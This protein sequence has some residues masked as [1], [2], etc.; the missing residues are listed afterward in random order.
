MKVHHI[1]ETW[2][3]G[4]AQRWTQKVAERQD[5][6]WNAPRTVVPH[7]SSPMSIHWSQFRLFPVKATGGPRKAHLF[8]CVHEW[9]PFLL[10]TAEAAWFLQ[11]WFRRHWSLFNPSPPI[12]VSSWIER[13]YFGCVSVKPLPGKMLGPMTQANLVLYFFMRQTML[14]FLFTAMK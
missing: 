9:Y 12:D 4:S 13:F 8:C 5:G 1:R 11:P 6:T 14:Y 2:N 7:G 3:S 10:P